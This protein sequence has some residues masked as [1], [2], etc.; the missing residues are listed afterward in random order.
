MVGKFGMF[1][2]LKSHFHESLA[3]HSVLSFKFLKKYVGK[4]EKGYLVK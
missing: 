3:D 1:F 2:S 4:N